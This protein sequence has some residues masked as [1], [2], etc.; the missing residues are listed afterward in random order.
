MSGL[1]VLVNHHW[2][3]CVPLPIT[4]QKWLFCLLVCRG[5]P[6]CYSVG[7]FSLPIPHSMHL[8]AP[9]QLYPFGWCVIPA[10]HFPQ[11]S[12]DRNL[13]IGF[14]LSPPPNHALLPLIHDLT[15][16]CIDWVQAGEVWALRVSS[17]HM[18][19][20]SAYCSLVRCGLEACLHS[21]PSVFWH[22]MWIAFLFPAPLRGW[23]FC[24][25]ALHFFRPISWLPSFPA[26]SLCHFCCNDLILLGLFRPAFYSFPQW[27]SMSIGF[28]THGL[29]CSFCLF[30]GHPCLICFLWASLALLLSLHS[31]EL[32]LTSLDFPSP[33]ILFSFLKFMGLPLTSYFLCL[34]YFRDRKSVV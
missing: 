26:M 8:V 5:T 3:V 14:S 24:Y 20:K 19:P 25:W 2:I 9:A 13:K 31:H 7:V 28:L 32:L 22:F 6:S 15:A 16:S 29:L 34:H 11:E 10:G 18:C 17:F 21:L 33:I 30:L 4:R 23:A 12:L 27:L 1:G